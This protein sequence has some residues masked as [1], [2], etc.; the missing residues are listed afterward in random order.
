MPIWDRFLVGD[1]KPFVLKKRQRSLLYGL[2]VDVVLLGSNDVHRMS[3][4]QGRVQRSLVI[5]EGDFVLR[6]GFADAFESPFA[7]TA[8]ETV[9]VGFW[10][11]A[12]DVFQTVVTAF[13]L[14]EKKRDDEVSARI[15]FYLLFAANRTLRRPRTPVF[16]FCI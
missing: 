10:F 16:C 14:S 11:Q 9:G 3:L 7:F 6:H 5:F 8:S 2:D 13:I 1:P 12:D 4:R 15:R